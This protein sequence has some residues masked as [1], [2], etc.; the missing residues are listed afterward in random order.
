[1]KINNLLLFLIGKR[2]SPFEPKTIDVEEELNDSAIEDVYSSMVAGKFDNNKRFDINRTAYLLARQSLSTDALA[3]IV[4]S[5]DNFGYYLAIPTKLL[6]NIGEFKTRLSIALPGQEGHKGDGAYILRFSKLNFAIAI[7][8]SNK[9]IKV[10][11]NEIAS[12]FEL[13]EDS[14]IPIFDCANER[15]QRFISEDIFISEKSADITLLTSKVSLSVC[16]LMMIIYLGSNVVIGLSSEKLVDRIN[17]EKKQVQDIVANITTSSPLS[18][19]LASLNRITGV[20]TRSGGWIKVYKI[21]SEGRESFEIEMP[22]WVSRD[23]LDALGSG[24]VTNIDRVNRVLVITK[25]ENKDDATKEIDQSTLTA[26][27]PAS[28]ASG[29]KI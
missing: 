24:I 7:I 1:M 18:K 23:Y 15:E 6:S 5:S 22:E 2:S 4:S 25:K 11:A 16:T 3:L 12:V 13:I 29:G 20:I 21:D 27:Q 26:S 17:K 10:V 28:K 9:T 8:V 14:D 19:N